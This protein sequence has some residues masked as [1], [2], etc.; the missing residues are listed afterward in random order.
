MRLSFTPLLALLSLASLASAQVL[1]TSTVEC[2]LWRQAHA[3]H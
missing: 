2:V 3:Y 1:L